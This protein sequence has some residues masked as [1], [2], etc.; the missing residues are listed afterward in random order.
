MVRQRLSAKFV[1]TTPVPASC[2]IR[3]PTVHGDGRTYGSIRD[4][5]YA[6]IPMKV[7]IPANE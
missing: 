4:E 1:H 7:A 2:H 3:L 6:Q 5:A